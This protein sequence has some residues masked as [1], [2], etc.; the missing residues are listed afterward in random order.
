[1]AMTLRTISL[2]HRARGEYREAAELAAQSLTLFEESGDELLAAYGAR[3][4]AK[5]WL[6]LGR[7]ADARGPLLEG[8]E[9]CRRRGDRWGEAIAL[10]TRGERHVVGGK[11]TEAEDRL[12]AAMRVWQ[13]LDL[14]LA[15]AR[16][17][18]DLSRLQQRRG[19]LAGGR[20]L[21]DEARKIF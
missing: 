12:N 13:T 6:R 5:A 16:T 20:R 9:V 17:L 15:Q 2:L 10:R 4:L 19:D 8:L 1:E 3:A 14:P 7:C 11:L 21:T 18:R